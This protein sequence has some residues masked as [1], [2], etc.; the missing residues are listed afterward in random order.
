MLRTHDR[1]REFCALVRMGAAGRRAVQS[2]PAPRCYMARQGTNGPVVYVG[3]AGERRGSRMHP[4]GL[5]GRLKVYASGKAAVSGLGEA[6][7]ERALADR[8]WLEERM[9]ELDRGASS[10]AKDW[11]QLAIQHLDLHLRWATTAD[12]A[13]LLTLR[14]RRWPLC[15]TSSC[16]TDAAEV[17]LRISNPRMARRSPSGSARGGHPGGGETQHAGSEVAARP[18]RGRNPSVVELSS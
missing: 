8:A 12:R 14:S 17:E 3:M 9:G 6:A 13:R 4:Q 15:A 2:P 5:R 1:R 11:A 7:L 10:R 18:V 16:G